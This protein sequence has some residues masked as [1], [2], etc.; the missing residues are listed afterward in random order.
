ME[1][2]TPKKKYYFDDDDC[3]KCRQLNKLCSFCFLKKTEADF[4][5]EKLKSKNDS[6]IK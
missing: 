1:K 6:A 4:I 5:Q 3:T 2:I